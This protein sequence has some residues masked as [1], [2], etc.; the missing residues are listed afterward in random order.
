MGGEFREVSRTR[1]RNGRISGK[2]IGYV[3]RYCQP[4]KR[5]RI[6]DIRCSY[7][8]DLQKDE[9]LYS[10]SFVVYQQNI[11]ECQP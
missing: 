6:M 1:T 9:Q 11:W 2:F 4:L 7:L 8:D 5:D 3:I 10:G